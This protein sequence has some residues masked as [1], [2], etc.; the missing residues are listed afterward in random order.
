[1]LK[2]EAYIK[3][4]LLSTPRVIK[5]LFNYLMK[6]GS[7]QNVTVTPL[8]KQNNEME[9]YVTKRM[10]GASDA[11]WQLLDSPISKYKPRKRKIIL[12]SSSR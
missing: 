8:S 12:L 5:Y 3:L 7:L 10:V 6:G 2:Y 9:Y 4:E 1:M 11:C